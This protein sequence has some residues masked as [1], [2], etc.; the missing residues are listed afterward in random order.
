MKRTGLKTHIFLDGF[1][2]EKVIKGEASSASPVTTQPD[3]WYF[4]LNRGNNSNFPYSRSA[5]KSPVAGEQIILVDGDEI[6]PIE[7]NRV[8]K[9]TASV[10]LTEGTIDVSDDCDPGAFILDGIVQISG[11]FAKLFNYNEITQEFDNVTD[12]LLSL[13][14]KTVNDDGEG[15]YEPIERENGTVYALINLNSDAKVGQMEH[16]FFIPI[17]ISDL[18]SS[19]GNTDAQNQDIT[20]V[21]GEGEAIHYKVIKKAA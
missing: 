13:F 19:F 21:K 6:Y 4:I 16:W 12:M 9:T 7:K 18:G 5:I 14:V 3:T 10:S 20:F 1:N 17:V 15:T 2:S 8:C 11:S